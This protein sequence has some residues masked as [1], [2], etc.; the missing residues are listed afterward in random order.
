M[1]RGAFGICL[2]LGGLVV[3]GAIALGIVF[4]AQHNVTLQDDDVAYL[5]E[6]ALSFLA[7]KDD[8]AKPP[9][10]PQLNKEAPAQPAVKAVQFKPQP[11]ELPPVFEVPPPAPPAA[12]DQKEIDAAIDKGVTYLKS[13]QNLNGTWGVG[14]VHAV[15]Y[16]ALPGLTLLECGASPKD[17]VVQ[18][19]AA[20]VRNNIPKLTKTYEL[21]LAILFLDR[22]G[23]A[24]DEGLI[25]TMALRLVAGQTSAGG[26]NYDVPVLKSADMDKLIVFLRRTRPQTST[27]MT[28]AK[29]GPNP[30]AG[31]MDLK[32]QDPLTAAK[33]PKRVG[34]NPA[35]R[36]GDN[37]PETPA[38]KGEGKLTGLGAIPSFDPDDK[39]PET[40]GGKAR[41]AS[42]AAASKKGFSQDGAKKRAAPVRLLTSL[43]AK[44]SRCRQP[45]QGQGTSET[46]PRRQ[47]Q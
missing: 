46:R 20:F 21:S 9:P 41:R 37:Q 32:T 43:L 24:R 11:P 16:A 10:E 17:P 30:L 22:L 18:K 27:P 35:T 15:G 14:A 12:V 45:R 8:H 3:L 25:R 44:H 6:Q 29:A 38:P 34:A 28:S 31:G 36:S 42:S 39:K 33:D 13:H 23:E 1:N 7:K 40:P 2:V 4:F 19:A 26:W 5:D 47:F